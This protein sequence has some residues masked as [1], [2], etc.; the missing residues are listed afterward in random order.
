M[1]T[2]KQH[3]NRLIHQK[4][5][6]S[7]E[8]IYNEYGLIFIKTLPGKVN[9]YEMT[10]WDLKSDPVV[11]LY[12]DHIKIHYWPSEPNTVICRHLSSK[13]EFSLNTVQ[14]CKQVTFANGSKFI[15]FKGMK[16]TYNG[17]PILPYPKTHVTQSRAVLNEL[18]ERKNGRNRFYYQRKKAEEFAP[19]RYGFRRFVRVD[20]SQLPITDVFKLQNISYRRHLINYFGMDA[21]IAGLDPVVIDTDTINRNPYAL[22]SVKFPFADFGQSDT[23]TYLRMVNP[24]TDE[25]H[26]EGVPNYDASLAKSRDS[27]RRGRTILWPTV[28]AAL[29][30]R[31]G[32]THYTVP[33]ILT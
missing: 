13:K 8:R 1:G 22:V 9:G 10:F 28:K 23:G 33:K 15:F 26:F 32:E 3:Y 17:N 7:R 21:I 6:A 29:A 16:L 14:G 11:S 24:S 20:V 25:I 31:D 30:W 12:K 5:Y 19:D 2:F 18:R 27:R 4:K